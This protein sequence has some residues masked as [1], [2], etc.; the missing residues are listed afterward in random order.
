MTSSAVTVVFVCVS[1]MFQTLFL[2]SIAVIMMSYLKELQHGSRS[3]TLTLLGWLTNL[4]RHPQAGFRG[5]PCHEIRATVATVP[6]SEHRTFFVGSRFGHQSG[7]LFL[8]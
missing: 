1:V 8:T 6:A 4:G 2:N 7:D 3:V 5:F